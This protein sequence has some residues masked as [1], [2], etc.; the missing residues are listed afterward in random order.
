MKKSE[1]NWEILARVENGSFNIPFERKTEFEEVTTSVDFT[2]LSFEQRGAVNSLTTKI[3]NSISSSYD[4]IYPEGD[5]NELCYLVSHKNRLFLVN[6]EGY[7]YSRYL[8]ELT[9][10]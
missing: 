1:R 8:V 5:D 6:N 7:Q 2:D 9:N 4:N 3:L 10:Y